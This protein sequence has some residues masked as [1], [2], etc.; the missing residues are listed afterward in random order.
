MKSESKLYN[1]SKKR[2][3]LILRKRRVLLK[4]FL[5]QEALFWYKENLIG[6]SNLWQLY[7]WNTFAHLFTNCDGLDVYLIRIKGRAKVVRTEENLSINKEASLASFHKL[8][9]GE[10]HI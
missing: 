5:K 3:D 9:W 1:V 8:A 10:Q 6:Y 7:I 2:P 4:H